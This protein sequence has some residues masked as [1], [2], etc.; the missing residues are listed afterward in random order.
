MKLHCAHDNTQTG[1]V[2]RDRCPLSLHKDPTI[3]L[4][5]TAKLT[6]HAHITQQVQKARQVAIFKDTPWERGIVP[7]GIVPYSTKLA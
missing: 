2:L 4:K 5:Y 3:Y 6:I 7:L 1:I